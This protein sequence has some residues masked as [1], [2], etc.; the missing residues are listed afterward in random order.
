MSVTTHKKSNARLYTIWKGMKQRCNNPN[1]TSYQNYGGRGIKVCEDWETDFA[2]FEEWALSSGYSDLLSID[3]IDVEKGYSPDNCRWATCST[4]SANT[5]K[6]H[7]HNKSGYRGV[8]WNNQYGKWEVSIMV[9]RSTTKI[10]YY[11]DKLQAA[12]AYDT[13]VK[14][15]NLEHTINGVLEADERVES[16]TGQVLSAVNTSGYRGV[17][18]PKRVQ[19]MK[20]PWYASVSVKKKRLWG[21]YF[22]DPEA[23]AFHRDK[24]IRDNELSNKLNFSDEEFAELKGALYEKDT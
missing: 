23:A 2:S 17:T 16:N 22:S 7:V 11:A 20:N 12:K 24:F 14:D 8:S 5:R 1:Q 15:N 4:Q 6:I 9:G 10:G 18:S 3:R 21:K 13:Y 19:Y